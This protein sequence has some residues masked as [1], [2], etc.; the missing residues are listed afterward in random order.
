MKDKKGI[1]NHIRFSAA[2][3]YIIVG[4]ACCTIVFYLYNIR[5]NIGDRKAEIEQ[6]KITLALTNNLV[7]TVSEI[8][9]LG[10]LYIS[11]NNKKYLTDYKKK[12]KDAELIMDSIALSVNKPLYQTGLLKL[13]TL[14]RE[15]FAIV[16]ELSNKLDR[17]NPLEDVNKTL[18]NYNPVK[19]MDSVIVTTLQYDT[20]V[21]AAPKQGFFKRLGRA[22]APKKDSVIVLS[23]QR[24]DTLHLLRPDTLTIITEVDSAVQTA[25]K[26]YYKNLKAIGMQVGSLTASDQKIMEQI[27]ELLLGM[28][29]QTL[30]SILAAIEESEKIIGR[31]YAYSIVGGVSALILVFIFI[32]LIINGVNKARMVRIAL[33]R[34]NQKD[35]EIMESRHKLLLSVSHDLK[36]PLNSILGYLELQRN[37]G[38]D[39][40]SMLSSGNYILSLWENLIE[41]SSIEQGKL[42]VSDAPFNLYEFFKVIT[43][44][45]E[46]LAAK[47]NIIFGYDLNFDKKTVI[48]SDQLKIKQIIVNLVSNGIKY[49][50]VG[51]VQLYVELEGEKLVCRVTDTGAGIPQQEHEKIFSP[52]C[53]VEKNNSL[54]EGSGLGLYVVKEFVELLG[55]TIALVSEVG[56][57]SEFTVMLPITRVEHKISG[58]AKKITIIDDDAVLLSTAAQMLAQLGHNVKTVSRIEDIE[59]CDMILAD[60]EMGAFT[61]IDVLK[62]AN[63]TPV[64]IMTARSDFGAADARSLGFAAYLSKPFTMASLQDVFD[65]AESVG[66]VKENKTAAPVYLK[67]SRC[68]AVERLKEMF[69]DDVES[70]QQTMEVFRISTAQN[71]QLLREALAGNDYCEARGLCHKMLPMFA[72]LGGDKAAALMRKVDMHRNDEYVQW[73]E[74]IEMIIIY[75]GEFAEQL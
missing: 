70:I 17:Q 27:S 25:E 21:N 32:A 35:K 6:Y 5:G 36:T 31:N 33:E 29:R 11:T 59:A 66:H 24:I 43:E 52:F 56:K 73:Q 37:Q 20:V 49:T 51:G 40:R 26:G 58:E 45:F 28:Y 14:L 13:D 69:G 50:A 75:A 12:I 46:P 60:M 44:M 48:L 8:Q 63:G 39:V 2:I 53:R 47:K 38:N 65:T 30:H 7:Y 15:Q 57:G 68:V 61:G 10:S 23:N 41:F 4:L 9:S 55:G 42:K 54:A 71:L 22:F 16:S 74:D 67:E 1:E 3:I 64:I 62:S 18:R 72:Q 19:K 34:L